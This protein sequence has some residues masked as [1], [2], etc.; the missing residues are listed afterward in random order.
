MRC[1]LDL[2]LEPFVHKKNTYV[3]PSLSVDSL[4]AAAEI[5]R[6]YH[7]MNDKDE[8]KDLSKKHPILCFG[9]T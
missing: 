4:R 7:P 5:W 2:D 1:I 3:K 8:L 6:R 9:C